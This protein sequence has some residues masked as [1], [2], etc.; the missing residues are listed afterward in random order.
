[1]ST[2]V[3]ISTPPGSGGIGI[4]R[5]S[6]EEAKYIAS[7]VFCTKKLKSFIDAEPNYMY[8]GNITSD[9]IAEKCFAVFF[10]SPHSYT[11]ED[12]VEFQCHGGAALIN[13]ITDILIE[14]G[15]KPADRG[16]FTKR[17]FLNGKMAL[18]DCEGVIEMI[19]ADNTASL[20]AGYRLMEGKLTKQVT[21]LQEM[22]TDVIAR[23]E[24]SLDYPEELEEETEEYTR[25][26]M[27]LI[28]KEIAELKNSYKYGKMIKDGVRVTLAG[29]TNVGKS[30]LLNAL[31]KKER[32][33]VTEIAGTTRDIIEEAIEYKGIKIIFTDTAGIRKSD[34]IVERVGIELAKKE[35]STADIVL[36]VADEK[37]DETEEQFENLIKNKIVI[38]I[39]NKIDKNPDKY[40]KKF[41]D[42]IIYI[43]C[44]QNK[45]IDKILDKIVEIVNSGKVTAGGEILILKRHYDAICEAAESIEDVYRN[46][47]IMEN[48]VRLMQLKNAW[49][50]LGY[51]TGTTATEEI[52][53]T[54]FKKFCLGK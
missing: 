45:N 36:F 52:I 13:K 34:D 35:I 43:S 23:G 37:N 38:R 2:I 10:K 41:D 18:A 14:R 42:G 17:A 53:D 50:K 26:K 11:G 25:E 21:A 32:A 7:E 22:L 48:C 16:E 5:I 46:Y 30:S 24:A 31:I 15:A 6:G 29:K 28:H 12:V 40:L 1:M 8:L 9:E 27:Q 44:K 19:N 39:I 51:I 4:I 3:A 54:I 33:I 20:N 47:D 49:D